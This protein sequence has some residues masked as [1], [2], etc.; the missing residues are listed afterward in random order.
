MSDPDNTR[1]RYTGTTYVRHSLSSLVFGFT[2]NNVR[3]SV[4]AA[5]PDDDA[6]EA[7][8][9]VDYDFDDSIEGKILDEIVDLSVRDGDGPSDAAK[10]QA[11]KRLKRQLADLAADACL[12]TMRRLA[13][14]QI[15]EA[16]TLQDALYPPTYTLQVFTEDGKLTCRTL[17]DDDTVVPEHH[18]AVPEERLRAMEPDLDTTGLLVVKPSQVILVRHLHNWVWSVTVNGEE[19]ICKASLHLFEHVVGDELSTYLKIRAAGVRL[20]VPEL[21][22]RHSPVTTRPHPGR[23]LTRY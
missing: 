2:F 13:P 9:P 10:Q 11:T 21:K 20:R 4:V 8:I 19:M 3:F 23:I 12:P 22:G 17:D 7:L 16:Q 1:P 14:T 18:P 6:G 5:S 15:P